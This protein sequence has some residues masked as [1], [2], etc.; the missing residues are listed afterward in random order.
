MWVRWVGG[1]CVTSPVNATP[2]H[3]RLGTPRAAG[4]PSPTQDERAG[5]E[6]NNKRR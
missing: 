4:A 6:E 5:E 1:V 3:Q 2:Y